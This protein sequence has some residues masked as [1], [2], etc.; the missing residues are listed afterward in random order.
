MKIQTEQEKFWINE[1]GN[2]Y[3]GRNKRDELYPS[4]MNLFADI[5]KNI[6]PIKSFIEFGPNMGINLLVLKNLF[7][8]SLFNAVEINSNAVEVLKELKICDKIWHDSIL[9]FKKK[10]IAD[11]A[12][13]SGVLIHIN[14]DYLEKAYNVLYESSTKYI[15]I[16]EYYNP[17]PVTIK[18]RGHENKLFK[19]DFA[20][21]ML[22]KYSDLNLLKYGFRY[23]QDNNF[24]LDDI[25]WFLMEKK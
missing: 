10:K 9:N 12:F 14:P 24:P 7:P 22:Q 4:K 11:F 6:F 21:E 19:R 5:V 1:F 16:C 23:K 3:I 25:T 17:T 20:G 8:N 13:T 15:L 2:N 18:Y